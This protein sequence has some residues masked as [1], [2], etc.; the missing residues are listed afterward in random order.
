MSQKNGNVQVPMGT[1]LWT[2]TKPPQYSKETQDL[3]KVMMQESKLTNFQQRQIR[4][5]M[6]SGGA[7]P[8]QCHPSTSN[9]ETR[10]LVSISRPAKASTTR[11]SLRPAERCRAGDAYTREKFQPQATRDLDKEKVDFRTLWLQG[12]SCQIYLK[13]HR[14]KKMTRRTGTDLMNVLK[15]ANHVTLVAEIQERWDFLE[16]MQVLGRGKQYYNIINTEISQ[17]LR[18]MEIIDKQRSKEL[19]EALQKSENKKFLS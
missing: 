4:E 19:Q 15:I 3:L 18:E 12:R 13:Y 7:L 8:I 5:Q 6:Q 9:T 1:G 11:P 2:N 17:K 10:P 16:E 14:H